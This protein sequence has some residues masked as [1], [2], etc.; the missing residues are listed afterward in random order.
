MFDGASPPVAGP[1]GP[2][3]CVFPFDFSSTP[4]Y[5]SSLLVKSQSP[6]ESHPQP[7]PCS[8]HHLCSKVQLG[9]QPSLSGILFRFFTLVFKSLQIM[10]LSCLPIPV[11]TAPCHVSYAVVKRFHSALPTAT[12]L[13]SASKTH[14]VI[15]YKGL[16]HWIWCPRGSWN[17]SPMDTEG[18]LYLLFPE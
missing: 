7:T 8:C 1:A 2:I 18:Q 14:Y 10:I 3:H 16:E 6:F 15:L 5:S 4:P 17:Q 11:P 13:H 9:T 12:S